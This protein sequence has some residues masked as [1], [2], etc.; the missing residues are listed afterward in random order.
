MYSVI[1]IHLT[2]IEWI[3]FARFAFDF[4]VCNLFYFEFQSNMKQHATKRMQATLPVLST[5]LGIFSSEAVA[6]VIII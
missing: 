4:L 2:T 6:A 3:V 1:Y 5:F